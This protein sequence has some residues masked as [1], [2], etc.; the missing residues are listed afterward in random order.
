MALPKWV[1]RYN[2]QSLAA[3]AF[4]ATANW[5][6]SSEELSSHAILTSGICVLY[7]ID[8]CFRLFDLNKTYEEM[9]E[10]LNTTCNISD[11]IIT[12][13][14]APVLYTSINVFLIAVFATSGRYE[15]NVDPGESKTSDWHGSL[16][17]L[18]IVIPYLVNTYFSIKYPLRSIIDDENHTNAQLITNANNTNKIQDLELA[19]RDTARTQRLDARLGD[20]FEASRVRVT[21][22]NEGTGEFNLKLQ[23]INQAMVV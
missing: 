19:S 5:Y 2:M 16:A 17:V 20:F 12:S 15:G 6:L 18:A 4:A 7:S 10:G 1:N 8:M 9:N 22:Q 23:R 11:K 13:T 3:T 21:A 14:Y